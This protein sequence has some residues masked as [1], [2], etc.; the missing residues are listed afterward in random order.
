M[1]QDKERVFEIITKSHVFVGLNDTEINLLADEFDVRYPERGEILVEEGSR[2]DYFYMV[3]R[4]SMRVFRTVERRQ[5]TLA[6]LSP[7]DYF[8]E[9]ALLHKQRRNASVQ[10][11]DDPG[12]ELP[13][14]FLLDQ[15]K[16]DSLLKK[17]PEIR[18]NLEITAHSNA[19]A[20]RLKFDWLHE[21]ETIYLL[22]RRHGAILFFHLIPP[23]L[24]GIAGALAIW[25]GISAGFSLLLYGGYFLA[26][27]CILWLLWSFIDWMNDYYILTNERV[28]WLEKILFLYDSRQEAPLRTLLS[29]ALDSSQ[30]ARWLG[31]GDVIVRT[32]TGQ[33]VLRDIGYPQPVRDLIDEHWKRSGERKKKA[34]ETAIRRII[35]QRIQQEEAPT[36]QPSKPA[37]PA[38]LKNEKPDYLTRIWN[39]FIKMRYEEGDAI[40]YRKHWLVLIARI[41]L[42]TIL[43]FGILFVVV[44]LRW[45]NWTIGLGLVLAAFLWWLYEYVDWRNDIFRVT[46]D[47]I[48]D[49]DRKP[50]GREEKKEGP[51][52][53]ILSME[54]ERIGLLR[55][56]FNFGDVNI[57]V[58]GTV[59]VFDNIFNPSQAQQDIFLRL[60]ALKRRQQEKKDTEER[61]R[62][63][64]WISIYHQEAKR[65][66]EGKKEES[67]N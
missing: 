57:D 40:T 47:K 56:L 23:A 66:Q 44:Y 50:L 22:A 64:Q 1:P 52:D 27:L 46:S 63:A 61:D 41:G 39:D 60:D 31:Y 42:P 55:I 67:E 32:F 10:V 19:L 16:F 5:E 29:L 15:K 65:D 4:G 26:G 58:S 8:G 11:V 59:F 43:I 33:I 51:L 49:I 45:L 28:V 53:N 12:G 48:F 18:R 36:T 54:V 9:E 6:I 21:N 17:H 37:R 30:I 34:D 3:Y 38:V 2:A 62:L 14:V 20:R 13:V 25:F 7:G 24:V 35:Q